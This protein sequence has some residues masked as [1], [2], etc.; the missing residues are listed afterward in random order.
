VSERIGTQ[1]RPL[2]VAVVGSG[3]SGFYAAGQLLSHKELTAEVDV[4]ER[5]PTPWGLV[6]GGVAPDHPKIK[7]VSRVYE[8]TAN[9]PGFRFFGN[10]EVGR[11]VSH[12]DLLGWYDAV[13]YSVGTAADRRSGIPGEELPGSHSA[14]E[15]VGWYNGHPDYRD[16]EFDLSGERAIVIGNGNVA[17]DVARMLTL[18]HD[19]LAVTDTADH[20]IDVFDASSV[21]E[22]VI[23]GR[24]GPQQAAFTNPEL[25]ELGELADADVVVDPADLQIE[26]EFHDDG[27]EG[28]AKR[29]MEILHQYAERPP[30]GKRKRVVLRFLTSPVE[31]L[32]DGKVEAIRV[33]RNRLT[34]DESGAL[35]ATPTDHTEVLDAGIV[36]RAIGYTGVALPGLPFDERRGVIPNEAG[37]VVDAERTYVAGWIKRGPSGVIGTNKKCANDT[38][39]TLLADLQAGAIEEPADAPEPAEIEAELRRRQPELVTYEG[40]QAIDETERAAGEPHGRPRVKLTTFDELIDAAGVRTPAA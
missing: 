35:R 3:P 30:S 6:R 17:I 7:S 13:L 27:L 36:F 20:A 28:T 8:K 39:A 2:R 10:V 37:R 9:K 31:I 40:W 4:Y 18:T 14:T 5:L 21:R 1:E 25:L 24:R 19:E 33:V 12:D 22:I 34:R 32:G 15:F 38:V 23:L 29:N 16:L 26:A 11:D